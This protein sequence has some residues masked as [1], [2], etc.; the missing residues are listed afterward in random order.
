[1]HAIL[2]IIKTCLKD[3]L[4]L[5]AGRAGRMEFWVFTLFAILIRIILF[6]LNMISHGAMLLGMVYAII[7]FVIFVAHYT[8]LI[9]RLHDT[10]RS[11]VH[12]APVFIGL[13][14]IVG[15]VFSSIPM[16]VMAGEVLSVGGLIYVLVLAVLPGNKGSNNYGPE[17]PTYR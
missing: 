17:A 11:A 16:L 12:V 8:A 4:F 7:N 5:A 2:A 1:M 6:P 9:R 3:K 14:L 15:A 10:N 13:L